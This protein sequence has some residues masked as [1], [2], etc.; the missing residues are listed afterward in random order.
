[1]GNNH[2]LFGAFLAPDF[3]LLA[4]ALRSQIA[5]AITPIK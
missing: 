4:L 2:A 1:M 5:W 3:Y